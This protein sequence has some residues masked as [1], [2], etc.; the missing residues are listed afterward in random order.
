M[1][2]Q[3]IIS[4]IRRVAKQFVDLIDKIPRKED[5]IF[6]KAMK[7]IYLLGETYDLIN[8]KTDPVVD[9]L[10]QFGTLEEK[11]NGPFVKLFFSFLI[12]DEFEINSIVLDSDRCL[13]KVTVPNNGTLFF[14]EYTYNHAKENKFHHT[15]GFDFKSLLSSVWSY[16]NGKIY[17]CLGTDYSRQESDTSFSEFQPPQD[18]IYGKA[19]SFLKEMIKKDLQYRIDDISRTYLFVGD[20]GIGKSSFALHMTAASDRVMKCDA[21]SI[22]N[23]S[24][25]NINFIIDNLEPEYLIID[26]IDKILWGSSLSTLLAVLEGLKTNNPDTVVILTAND[27]GVIDKALLRPGRIDEIIEFHPQDEEEQERILRG[28]LDKFNISI[29]DDDI[30]AVVSSTEG[31]TAAYIREV[32]VQLKYKAVKDVLE[33]VTIMRKFILKDDEGEDLL[34]QDD[35]SNEDCEPKEAINE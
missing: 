19:K 3:R 21:R 34:D 26:D 33:T 7:T 13:T 22:Q 35:G 15:V 12:K 20:P 17:T 8:G 2:N 25:E 30:K 14:T 6:S 27:T 1:F 31:L 18:V 23:A 32:A 5:N 16:Y 24:T 11:I 28:Y 29:S 10:S 4:N 9:Y